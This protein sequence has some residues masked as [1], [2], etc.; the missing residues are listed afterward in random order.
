MLLSRETATITHELEETAKISVGLARISELLRSSLRSV[1]G[2]VPAEGG[3]DDALF[4]EGMTPD[5]WSLERECE[6]VRLEKENEA[7]RGLLELR[8]TK[9][10]QTLREEIAKETADAYARR[11]TQSD[12]PFIPHSL[13]GD[14]TGP[15]IFSPSGYRGLGRGGRRGLGGRGRARG[16]VAHPGAW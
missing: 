11:T 14:A 12:S 3:T 2:E 7:L 10:T 9:D 6:L 15:R 5:V 8:D 1:G 4:F 16:Y 13:T